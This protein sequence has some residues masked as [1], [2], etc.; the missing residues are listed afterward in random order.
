MSNSTAQNTANLIFVSDEM[1]LTLAS[2]HSVKVNADIE[3]F[4]SMD[5]MVDKILEK[6]VARGLASPSNIIAVF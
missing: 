1:I 2:G 4:D 3:S 6:A 5:D